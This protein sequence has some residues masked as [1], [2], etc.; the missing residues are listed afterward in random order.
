[1]SVHTVVM[2]PLAVPVVPAGQVVHVAEPAGLYCPEAHG[3]HE[4]EPPPLLVPA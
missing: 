2:S 4:N 1:M 3:V